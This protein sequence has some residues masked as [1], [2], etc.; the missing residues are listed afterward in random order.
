MNS[1]VTATAANENPA[2]I[3]STTGDDEEMMDLIE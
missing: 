2:Q 3:A 1:G